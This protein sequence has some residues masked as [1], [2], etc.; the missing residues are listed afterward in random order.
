MMF[1]VISY[2]ITIEALKSNDMTDFSFLLA[3]MSINLSK[4]AKIA[5]IEV[6][7]EAMFHQPYNVLKTN[8]IS[9]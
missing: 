8:K 6:Y 3:C 2:S 1:I 4:V 5:L 7:P 9:Q